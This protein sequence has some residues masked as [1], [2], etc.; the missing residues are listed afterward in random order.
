MTTR[1]WGRASW[2]AGGVPS[3]VELR[4]GRAVPLSLAPWLGGVPADL[5]EPRE[6]ILLVLPVAPSKILCV[7]R[8]YRAHAAEL[9]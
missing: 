3:Y 2:G 9:G 4:D 6:G 1:H 7:A 5:S 8:N